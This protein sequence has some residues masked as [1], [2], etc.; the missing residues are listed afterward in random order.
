MVTLGRNSVSSRRPTRIARHIDDWTKDVCGKCHACSGTLLGSDSITVTV[1]IE[2]DW[3]A[4]SWNARLLHLPS[5]SAAPN[6]SA[7]RAFALTASSSRFLDGAL[8][9]SERS[10]RLE[11]SDTSSTA[12]RNEASFAFDG[13]VKSADF[14]H[15]LERRRSNLFGINRRIEIEKSFDIP[16]H[17]TTSRRKGLSGPG[18]TRQHV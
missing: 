17:A 14:P 5:L 13:F 15:E 4:R 11:I 10:R 12:A 7:A 1:A 6:L 16:T 3:Q 2:Q 9:S 8:V 18:K